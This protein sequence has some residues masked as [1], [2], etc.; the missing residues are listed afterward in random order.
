MRFSAE[1]TVQHD[2]YHCHIL[3]KRQRNATTE[4]LSGLVPRPG[5][6]A[7]Q[8]ANATIYVSYAGAI[9]LRGNV[10]QLNCTCLRQESDGNT[11]GKPEPTNRFFLKFWKVSRSC[12]PAFSPDP[13]TFG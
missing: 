9:R 4:V 13:N 6:C 3:H 7:A 12:G 11:G 8:D 10:L 2:A 5:C 1:M